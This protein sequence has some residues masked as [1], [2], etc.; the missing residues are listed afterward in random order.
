MVINMSGDDGYSEGVES[1]DEKLLSKKTQD[2][3][4]KMLLVLGEEGLYKHQRKYATL[5]CIKHIHYDIQLLDIAEN[6]FKEAEKQDE[7]ALFVV[8]RVMRRVA[9]VAYRRL[10]KTEPDRDVNH[11][12]FLRSIK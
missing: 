6:F 12:R 4:L 8:G 9:H 3:F 10:N 7:D 2:H 11:A 5:A 1:D